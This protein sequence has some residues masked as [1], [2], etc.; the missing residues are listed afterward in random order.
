MSKVYTVSNKTDIDWDSIKY[1]DEIR[2]RPD[3]QGIFPDYIYAMDYFRYTLDC[4]IY[5]SPN[6]KAFVARDGH[7]K[8]S[9]HYLG[10]AGDWFTHARL[11]RV[12]MALARYNPF[13]GIGIYFDTYFEGKPCLMLHTDL[14]ISNDAITKS[15]W[16]R[17]KHS[18]SKLKDSHGY[19]SLG[20]CGYDYTLWYDILN[21]EADKFY[22]KHT[23]IRTIR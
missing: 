14:R 17:N 22:K 20:K 8:T 13:T 2:S 15:W 21:D 9:Q 6:P 12:M 19:I 11:E 18:E 16:I 4:P 23:D 7:S 5:A 1:I 10:R 3:I